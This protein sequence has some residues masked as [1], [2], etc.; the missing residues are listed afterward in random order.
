[1]RGDRTKWPMVGEL[2]MLRD[3]DAPFRSGV[4]LLVEVYGITD[5]PAVQGCNLSQTLTAISV[6]EQVMLL[7]GYVQRIGIG[8][9]TEELADHNSKSTHVCILSGPSGL[10]CAL[11]LDVHE[12]HSGDGELS[13]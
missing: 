1:M 8:W 13:P 3:R 7:C 11:S 4:G 6:P 12:L 5:L 10:V 9:D 2:V